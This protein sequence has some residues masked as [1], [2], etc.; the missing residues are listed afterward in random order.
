M[1]QETSESTAEAVK[2][3]ERDFNQCFQ[4]MRHYDAQILE[5]CKFAV[6]AYTAVI[7]ASLA[8]Y[9]YGIDK[10]IEY[11]VPAI[12]IL[13]AGLLL[14][15]CMT[16]LVARNRAYFVFVV[17][18][19]NEQRGF[20]LAKRPLGFE[21]R[22]RMYTNPDFPAFFNWRSSQ[23]LLL[24]VLSGLNSFLAGSIV[25]LFRNPGKWFW[26]LGSAGICWLLQM[27]LSVGYLK[28]REHKSA[29]RAISGRE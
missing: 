25:F 6:T 28:S 3:L 27:A 8:L 17:R 12:G 16:A 14:G 13:S 2:F 20:F 9:K 18:Y 29:E 10:G 11:S 1:S 7:G 19:I 5:I 15:L 23:T 24:F 26:V 4:Q 21:N 22:T